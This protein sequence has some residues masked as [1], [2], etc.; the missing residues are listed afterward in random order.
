[1]EHWKSK[2]LLRNRHIH[3]EETVKDEGDGTRSGHI[4]FN[5]CIPGRFASAYDT[6]I[7]L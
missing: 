1:M 2:P 7:M 6:C 3:Q 5:I 4:A